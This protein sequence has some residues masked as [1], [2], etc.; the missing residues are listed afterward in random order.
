MEVDQV[1]EGYM[2]KQIGE[3]AATLRGDHVRDYIDSFLLEMQKH[4]LSY[5]DGG[6]GPHSKHR[7]SCM[8]QKQMNGIFTN[9]ISL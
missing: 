3:H 2:E 8:L 6:C 1:L 5:L 4:P 7:F 9:L